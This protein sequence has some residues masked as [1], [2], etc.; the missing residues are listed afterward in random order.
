M[1]YLLP[2][3]LLAGAIFAGLATASF[4]G[5]ELT[6]AAIQSAQNM[7]RRSET[8]RARF[9]A[10][11]LLPGTAD[12]IERLE[13][14]TEF[15][16]VVLVTEER[17]AAGDWTFSSDTR[18]AGAA[19]RPW[20]DKVAIRARIRFHPHH[21]YT[22]APPINIVIGAG[23]NVHLPIELTAKQQYGIGT[24][25]PV[26]IGVIVEGSFEAATVGP[27]VVTVM[28]VGPGKAEVRRTV[29]LGSLR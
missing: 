4:E 29:D 28:V 10:P 17:L 1:R 3:R 5:I 16:R 22:S 14:I 23:A 20:K 15:R 9:H 27:R 7:A 12:T 18:A 26:M 21:L 19:I 8:D 2:V 24:D 25:P 6:V 13:V 11:Y